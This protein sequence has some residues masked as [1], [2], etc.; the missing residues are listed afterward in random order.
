MLHHTI[1]CLFSVCLGRVKCACRVQASPQL[2]TLPRCRHSHCFYLGCDRTPILPLYNVLPS[3]VQNC[4]NGL[5]FA[6]SA[7]IPKIL[8]FAEDAFEKSVKCVELIVQRVSLCRALSLVYTCISQQDQKDCETNTADSNLLEF[9]FV[10][11]I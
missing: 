9:F 2:C 11:G 3:S 4:V 7:R 10:K 1:F 8:V 5:Q 6:P